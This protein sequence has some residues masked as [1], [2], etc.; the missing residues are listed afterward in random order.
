MTEEAEAHHREVDAE[1]DSEIEA[2]VVALAEEVEVDHQEGAEVAE[3]AT[4]DVAAEEAEAVLE[5][6]PVPKS[7]SNPTKDLPESS[8]LEEKTMPSSQ[9]I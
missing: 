5:S 4:V 9:K 7:W 6:A 2:V 1:A 8:S 3:V